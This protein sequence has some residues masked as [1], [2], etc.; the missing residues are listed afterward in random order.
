MKTIK[1]AFTDFWPDFN[2]QDNFLINSLKQN[3]IVELSNNPDF[4]FCSVFGTS[5][6]KYRCAKIFYTGENLMPDFNLVDYGIGFPD[7]KFYDRYLRYPLYIVYEDAMKKALTKESKEQYLAR[8]KF[9]NYVISNSLADD[10]R[11]RIIELL[12]NYKK[13][14]SGGKYRNNVGGPVKDKIEFEKQYKFTL[15]IENTSSPG[16]TTE[17]IIEAFAGGTIPIYWG[18]PFVSEDFNPESFINVNDFDSFEDMVTYV[19]RVD[20]DDELY[21]KIVQSPI[22]KDDS[23]VKEYISDNYLSD[24]LFHICNQEPS[25]AIRRNTIYMGKYYEDMRRFH[26]RSD[27]L[28]KQPRRII[29]GLKNEIRKRKK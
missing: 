15:A 23:R 14:D 21:L 1:V 28:L 11:D 22:F 8:T 13:V 20:S 27:Q 24:Y 17:K 4:V 12:N 18:N 6:L 19:K 10:A 3:F 25:K 7:I 16:Y 9:C 29:H 26:W 5:H 2:P